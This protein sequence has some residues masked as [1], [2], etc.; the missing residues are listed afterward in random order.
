MTRLAP[1]HLF[2]IPFTRDSIKEYK[3]LSYEC[4]NCVI[5]TLTAMKMR[6]PR[7]SQIDTRNIYHSNSRGISS[8]TIINYLSNLFD[9]KFKEVCHKAYKLSDL[10]IKNGYGTCISI[11]FYNKYNVESKL[12]DLSQIKKRLRQISKMKY[13]RNTNKLYK[14]EINMKK[15]TENHIFFCENRKRQMENSMKNGHMVILYKEND[16]LYFYD[17]C[18]GK[19]KPIHENI[20]YHDVKFISVYYNENKIAAPLIKERMNNTIKYHYLKMNKD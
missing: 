16:I 7:I 10:K 9:T 6:D 15:Y 5:Q 1:T 20:F 14:K 13:T 12:K 18:N 19:T 2:Q 17:P 4:N 11:T 3:P 8:Q